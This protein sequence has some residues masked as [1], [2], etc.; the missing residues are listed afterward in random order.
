MALLQ[1]LRNK[2]DCHTN[3]WKGICV[4][5]L[6]ENLFS[7]AIV[8]IVLVLSDISKSIVAEEFYIAG[9]RIRRSQMNQRKEVR[10]GNQFQRGME[11]GINI[12]K[13]K[14]IIVQGR[15]SFMSLTVK[16]RGRLKNKLNLM[17]ISFKKKLKD[18][19]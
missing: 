5:L 9:W 18:N 2:N 10:S 8:L 12:W 16:S 13:R 7:S 15:I 19:N 3:W 11:S 17:E 4:L 1:T 6:A 14:S